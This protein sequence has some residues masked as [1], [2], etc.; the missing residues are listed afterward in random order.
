M[1]LQ[2]C[3]PIYSTS[4]FYNLLHNLLIKANVISLQKKKKK[5]KANVINFVSEPI[6]FCPIKRNISVP[7]YFDVPFLGV[8]GSL[9]KYNIYIYIYMWLHDFPGPTSVDQA[10]AQSTTHNKYL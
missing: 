2:Q 6:L 3:Y 7:T 1:Y 9:K 8:S 4:S 10:L 5:K